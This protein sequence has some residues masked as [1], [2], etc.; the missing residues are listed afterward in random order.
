MYLTR[1]ATKSYLFFRTFLAEE[2]RCPGGQPSL[3]PGGYTK[4]GLILGFRGFKGANRLNPLI[5][6][7]FG[8]KEGCIFRGLRGLNKILEYGTIF[9]EEF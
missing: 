7:I 1:K 4:G 5:F 3:T 9:V 6:S 2:Q 8:L